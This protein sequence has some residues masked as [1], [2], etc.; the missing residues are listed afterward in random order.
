[1]GPKVEAALRFVEYGGERAVITS[2]D[3]I[4]AA[5]TG[6]AGTVVPD[7]LGELP[8]TGPPTREECQ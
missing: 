3:D 4:G 1:M 2:L 6:A 5:L 7:R 8:K